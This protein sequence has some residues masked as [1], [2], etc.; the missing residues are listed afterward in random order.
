MTPDI[1]ASDIYLPRFM[2]SILSKDQFGSYEVIKNDLMNTTFQKNHI[3]SFEK[4]VNDL[5]RGRKLSIP[6]EYNFN[7]FFQVGSSQVGYTCHFSI[8]D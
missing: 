6:L 1:A 8:I 2:Q 3:S 7:K 4:S 5:K